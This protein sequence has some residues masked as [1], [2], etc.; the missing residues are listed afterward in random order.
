MIHFNI[1]IQIDNYVDAWGHYVFKFPICSTAV[2]N[3]GVLP[4]DTTISSVNVKAYLGRIDEQ[5]DLSTATEVTTLIEAS[6]QIQ[7]DDEVAIYLQH[8]GATHVNKKIGLVFELILSEG[9]K[10][11]F[12]GYYIEIGWKAV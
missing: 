6:P 9:Q 5:T 8:P 3:D 4:Y 7:N 1:D 2:T 12:Y 10:K 11:S